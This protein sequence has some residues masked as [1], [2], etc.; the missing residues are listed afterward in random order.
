[1]DK[2]SAFNKHT[3]KNADCGVGVNSV[4]L[5]KVLD[6]AQIDYE[7]ALKEGMFIIWIKSGLNIQKKHETIK[8]SI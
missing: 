5:F 8:L 4:D 2:T 3:T 7:L 6:C 1:M